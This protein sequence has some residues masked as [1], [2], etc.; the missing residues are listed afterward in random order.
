MARP[1]IWLFV[2]V[3]ALIAA[4]GFMIG[5]IREGAG[6]PVVLLLTSFWVITAQRRWGKTNG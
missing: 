1:P 5:Q 4:I 6:M 3:A 2:A